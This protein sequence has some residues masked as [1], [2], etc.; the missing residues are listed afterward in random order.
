MVKIPKYPTNEKINT[1]Y[2]VNNDDNE[3]QKD[4]IYH[5]ETSKRK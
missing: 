1:K 2:I 4:D 3:D 5:G